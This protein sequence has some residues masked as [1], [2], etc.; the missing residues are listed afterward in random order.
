MFISCSNRNS[1]RKYWNNSRIFLTWCFTNVVLLSCQAFLKKKNKNSN[2]TNNKTK[3]GLQFYTSINY[4][5]IS[6]RYQAMPLHGCGSLVNTALAAIGN[7]I[8]ISNAIM[9]Y[10]TISIYFGSIYQYRTWPAVAN[11]EMSVLQVNRYHSIY[12]T[13]YWWQVSTLDM[14]V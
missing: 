4:T 14:S 12:S 8:T 2:N 11:A 13:V 5:K 7:I 3:K 10:C 9:Y 1:I 6:N